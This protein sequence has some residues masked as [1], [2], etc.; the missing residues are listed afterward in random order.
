[1]VHIQNIYL[2]TA[3]L[4]QKVIAYRHLH[5]DYVKNTMGSKEG[6]L[7][8][9]SVKDGLLKETIVLQKQIGSLLK[10]NVSLFFLNQCKKKGPIKKK[11]GKNIHLFS[12]YWMMWIIISAYTHFDYW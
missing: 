5:Y 9:L 6:R 2:Y 1:M 12:L 3:Y 8:H 10:C 7:R 4:E 11:K